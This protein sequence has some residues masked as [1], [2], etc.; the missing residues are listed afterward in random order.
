MKCEPILVHNKTKNFFWKKIWGGGT[1]KFPGLP[2][3]VWTWRFHSAPLVLGC[4]TTDVSVMDL[5]QTLLML[6]HSV[7]VVSK[8]W[9][10]SEGD[11]MG[12][13]EG[14]LTTSFSALLIT[15]LVQGPEVPSG[16]YPLG[17]P[18]LVY[19][20]SFTRVLPWEFTRTLIRPHSNGT[21]LT[22]SDFLKLFQGPN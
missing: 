14:I 16:F 22:G 13:R 6:S 8:R 10:I 9:G 2:R 20:W 7:E 15:Q 18:S 4:E 5:G 17:S 1:S 3:H 11:P 12:E 21:L 19:P